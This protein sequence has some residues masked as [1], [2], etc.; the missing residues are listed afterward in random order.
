MSRGSSL[1]TISSCKLFAN[2]HTAHILKVKPFGKWWLWK[3]PVKTTTKKNT[4]KSPSTIHLPLFLHL[5]LLQCHPVQMQSLPPSLHLHFCLHHWCRNPVMVLVRKVLHGKWRNCD[6]EPFL[7]NCKGN[8][9]SVEGVYCQIDSYLHCGCRAKLGLRTSLPDGTVERLIVILSRSQHTSLPA[10][11][12]PSGCPWRAA[13]RSWT[14]EGQC[15]DGWWVSGVVALTWQV[16]DY[17]CTKTA[18]HWDKTGVVACY[19]WTVNGKIFPI[20]HLFHCSWVINVGLNGLTIV[21]SELLDVLVSEPPLPLQPHLLVPPI[22]QLL[23]AFVPECRAHPLLY[24]ANTFMFCHWMAS[25]IGL[26][27]MELLE[28]AGITIEDHGSV[29]EHVQFYRLLPDVGGSMWLHCWWWPF[30]IGF[31]GWLRLLPPV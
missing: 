7:E 28:G 18:A 20:Q 8:L 31:T 9:A 3:N 10:H 6:P 1:L 27:I 19:L 13:Q 2:T 21:L 30:I 29:S 26:A 22:Y 24:M 25:T 5:L 12:P 17:T 16:H 4:L 23:L 15:Q 14:D 11:I